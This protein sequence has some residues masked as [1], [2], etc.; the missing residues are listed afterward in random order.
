MSPPIG[1]HATLQHQLREQAKQANYYVCVTPENVITLLDYIGEL[2]TA[3]YEAWEDR[4]G[5]DL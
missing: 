3:V 2:E 5:E 1:R 4:L